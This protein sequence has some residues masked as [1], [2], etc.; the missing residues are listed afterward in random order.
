MCRKILVPVITGLL[1]APQTNAAP[2]IDP[3]APLSGMLAVR[4]LDDEYPSVPA[5]MR[6]KVERYA[7]DGTVEGFPLTNTIDDRAHSIDGTARNVLAKW[8][9]PL[10]G[11]EGADAARQRYFRIR[12]DSPERYDLGED[13][14]NDLGYELVRRGLPEAG[15]AMLE[16]NLELFPNS[17]N[18]HDSLAEVCEHIGDI[19]RARV[20]YQQA[21]AIDPQFAHAAERLAALGE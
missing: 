17:A 16:F 2:A 13:Q 9:D 11:D 14:L 4:L 12:E 10:T 7:K 8:L 1:V 3:S 6:A 21:L 20:L 5:M 15:I 19:D 18:A